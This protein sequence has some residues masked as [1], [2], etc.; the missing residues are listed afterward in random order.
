MDV[1]L[2]KSV[3]ISSDLHT[4]PIVM[5]WDDEKSNHVIWIIIFIIS[6][7]G[8]NS[9]TFRMVESISMWSIP[10]IVIHDHD[11]PK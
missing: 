10:I 8:R 6:P 1:I 4:I 11:V 7:D 9:E 2:S 5:E 3:C